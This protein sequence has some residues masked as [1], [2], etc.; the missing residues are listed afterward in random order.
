MPAKWVGVIEQRAGE[1]LERKLYFAQAYQDDVKYVRCYDRFSLSAD[2][3]FLQHP[4][5]IKEI[6]I[7]SQFR[8]VV[9]EDFL[10]HAGI[11]IVESDKEREVVLAGEAL[12][13]KG[14]FNAFSIWLPQRFEDY[15]KKIKSQIAPSP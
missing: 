1:N 8:F 7:D 12:T 2:G 15:L 10:Q 4:Y 14:H 9:P 13:P 6:S 11:S 5:L 3:Y